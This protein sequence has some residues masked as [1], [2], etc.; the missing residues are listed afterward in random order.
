MLYDTVKLRAESI[1]GQLDGSIPSTDDGQRADSSTLIDASQIDVKAMGQFSMG[2]FGGQ[3]EK[4]DAKN[5]SASEASADTTDGESRPD[6]ESRPDGESMSDSESRPDGES[7]PASEEQ[8][9]EASSSGETP[10]AGVHRQRPSFGGIPG[11]SADQTKARTQ[12]LITFGIC[13]AVM[14]AAL[15]VVL[16]V[17]RK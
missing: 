10:T 14:L 7:S 4:A 11:Q 8:A 5:G 6:D 16:R 17:K 9:S 12:N 3:H 2:G 15:L 1:A 13:F